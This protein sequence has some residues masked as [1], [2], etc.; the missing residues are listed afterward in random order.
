[1]GELTV[2]RFKLKRSVLRPEGPIYSDLMVVR[3]TES[4]RVSEG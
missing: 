3:A 2:D 4:E 1:V